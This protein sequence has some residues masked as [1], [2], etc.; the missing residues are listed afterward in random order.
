MASCPSPAV[1]AFALV[2]GVA[3]RCAC[4][5]P[6][7]DVDAG[8]RANAKVVAADGKHLAF[9]ADFGRKSAGEGMELSFGLLR[10]A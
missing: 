3:G 5:C 6:A 10:P 2:A 7:A 4:A 9:P 8:E 1:L